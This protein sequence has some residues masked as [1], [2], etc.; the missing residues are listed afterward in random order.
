MTPTSRNALIV[1]GA[2]I[3]AAL[4]FT[5]GQLEGLLGEGD[6]SLETVAGTPDEPRAEAPAVGAGP[7]AV[8]GTALGAAAAGAA[9]G[10]EAGSDSAL[11]EQALE[12]GAPVL[13]T[14]VADESTSPRRPMDGQG[15][16]LVGIPVSGQAAEGAASGK[17]AKKAAPERSQKAS[18]SPVAAGPSGPSEEALVAGEDP[19]VLAKLAFDETFD[20]A[21][22]PAGPVIGRF[23]PPVAALP[24]ARLPMRRDAPL[25]DG[26]DGIRRPC[27]APGAGCRSQAAIASPTPADDTVCGR[28][29]AESARNARNCTHARSI[30]HT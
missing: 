21:G 16:P 15:G 13:E 12:S 3:V 2:L 20:E 11:R 10:A 28:R 1:G 29:P 17:V 19:I 9:L 23:A 27:D 4:L 5:C 6:S 24:D 30:R 22:G 14:V 8:L 18:A 25:G 7:P 26:I